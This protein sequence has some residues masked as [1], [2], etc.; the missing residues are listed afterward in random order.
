MRLAINNNL[1]LFLTFVLFFNSMNA[2]VYAQKSSFFDELSPYSYRV[3]LEENGL[4]E[5]TVKDIAQSKDG[6][7]WVAT[8][9][10]VARFDGKKFQVYDKKNIKNLKSYII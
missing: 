9:E 6:Y 5:N 4:P 3:W 2:N 7:L 8:Y 1:V 10:G